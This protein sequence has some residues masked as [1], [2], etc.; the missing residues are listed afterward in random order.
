MIK[1][2]GHQVA[3][4]KATHVV[5]E[6][7]RFTGVVTCLSSLRSRTIKVPEHTV[8]GKKRKDKTLLFFN[9]NLKRYEPPQNKPRTCLQGDESIFT[10]HHQ[11]CK[12]PGG[13]PRVIFFSHRIYNTNIPK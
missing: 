10:H 7:L 5:V 4:V 3:L 6:G 1:T 9:N 12:N 13:S 11:E 8:V 2:Y